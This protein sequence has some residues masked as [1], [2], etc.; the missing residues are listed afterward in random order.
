MPILCVLGLWRGRY[1]SH[2]HEGVAWTAAIPVLDSFT[3]SSIPAVNSVRLVYY[4]N[5]TL[6]SVSIGTPI[7]FGSR[8]KIPSGEAIRLENAR[9]GSVWFEDVRY[10]EP[11]LP[12]GRAASC[13]CVESFECQI[14]STI[15]SQ[16]ATLGN[17]GSGVL[18][19][20]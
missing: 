2:S 6:S 7:R 1:S 13:S 16:K 12:R 3:E 14:W 20:E 4:S 18:E 9:Y 5:H 15:R 11:S 17:V 8:S 19:A 10:G